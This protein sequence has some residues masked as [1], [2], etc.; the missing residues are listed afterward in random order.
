MPIKILVADDEPAI[1]EVVKLYLEKEGFIVYTAEDGDIAIA[2]ETKEQ[3]DLLILDVMLPKLSGWDICQTIQRSVPVIFLT[4][5]S[6]ESDKITGFSL[7][8]DDYITKPFSPKELVA[9]IKAVLRRSGLLQQNGVTLDFTEL[10]INPAS[11]GVECNGQ[12]ASLSPKEFELLFFLARHP[13]IAFSREQ[14]LTNVWGYDFDG[15]DRTVDATIKRLRQKLH[16]SN[17]SY[18]H[19]VWG[20][21]YKFEVLGK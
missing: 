21:G 3:P 4:A 17:Y 12:S 6:A 5:K 1:C 8:A 20:I 15:D 18:I 7:G 14:L 9:R 16:N 19:T 2:I 11:Q 13:Q 10:S